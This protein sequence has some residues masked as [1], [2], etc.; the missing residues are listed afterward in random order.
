MYPSSPVERH[1]SAP[2]RS[3]SRDAM[4]VPMPTVGGTQSLQQARPAKPD[5]RQSVIAWF[6]ETEMPRGV[7]KDKNGEV[8][9]WFHGILTRT[10]AENLLNDKKPGT[11]LVRV[12]EKIWG[13]TISVKAKD[14]SVLC[15]C[16]P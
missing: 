2:V 10:E 12:S 4:P 14:R 6:K 1:G 8:N 5:S 13:Y 16:H 7:L 3:L 9:K 11:F 15:E